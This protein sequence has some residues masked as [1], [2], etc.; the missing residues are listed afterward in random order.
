MTGGRGYDE[1]TGPKGLNLI[2]Y[3][4]DLGEGVEPKEDTRGDQPAAGTSGQEQVADAKEADA[5]E[6]Q[7]PEFEI[8]FGNKAPILLED[9]ERAAAAKKARTLAGQAIAELQASEDIK[10]DLAETA[11]TAKSEPESESHIDLGF[12]AKIEPQVE[13]ENIPELEAKASPELELTAREQEGDPLLVMARIWET[14]N[15][16]KGCSSLSTTLSTG[17]PTD[18]PTEEPETG[19]N[20]GQD[21]SVDAV[22][23]T[24]GEGMSQDLPTGLST[25]ILTDTVEGNHS[26]LSTGLSTGLSTDLSTVSK[27]VPTSSVTARG[28][29]SLPE[30]S[31]LKAGNGSRLQPY[32]DDIL[33]KANLLEETLASFGV[34]A[35]VTDFT[36]GP[37]ITRFEVQP[38]PGVKVSRIVGLADDIALALAATDVRIE[39]PIPGR[40]VVGIEVPN[41]DSV[42]VFL[43]EVLVSKEFSN[44][45]SKLAVVLGKDIGGEPVL[46]DLTKM[47]HLLVAGSTGSGKSVCMNSLIIS[48]LYKARPDEVKFLLVDPKMVE[49]STYN[50]IPHLIAPVITDP[51]QAT[52]ALRWVVTEMEN[53]YNLFAQSGVKNLESYNQQQKTVG[54]QALPLIVVLIDELADLM[55][56]ASRD[57]EDTICRLAQM[58]R[59]AGIHL[60]IATQR[61]SVDVIT[62]IIKA[63]IPSRIAFAVSSQVDSRTILDMSGAEKLQGKGDMLFSPIGASKPHRIQGA[64]V[65]DE[66]VERV[67]DHWK[68]Q[69]RPDYLEGV[70]K[71]DDSK[72]AGTQGEE[73][74]E[75][76][77]E[78]ARLIIE[79]KQASVSMLQRRFRIGYNRAARLIDLLEDKG[80]VGGFEGSKPREVLLTKEEWEQ[81]FS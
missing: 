50:G 20:T 33:E 76:L 30:I 9:L 16:N 6:K 17:L 18:L 72:F 62:G 2:K 73:E 22:A 80:F 66:E 59:A 57:V 69:A 10:T 44:A 47:P 41:P 5:K 11:A 27:D 58:A 53:R 35:Q 45:R 63:N 67:V 64:L 31:L 28:I 56:V 77:S 13:L 36:Q 25:E 29:F 14:V 48:I 42:P 34:K 8:L 68:A 4:K 74:D 40:A 49:L 19:S 78:A 60:V 79:N 70:F 7:L 43:K 37:T 39:A 21:I 12:E 71:A 61:P 81:I 32:T 1:I 23:P 51:K 55:M 65:T 75:L 26:R 54:G 3:V 24:F 46:A 15:E 52:A 38:A